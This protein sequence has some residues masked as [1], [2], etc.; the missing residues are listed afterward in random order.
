M[1]SRAGAGRAGPG[2]EGRRRGSGLG[3]RSMPSILV[4]HPLPIAASASPTPLTGPAG[5]SARASASTSAARSQVAI[6][7]PSQ[8]ARSGRA[9]MRIGLVAKRPSI[10]EAEDVEKPPEL[11]VVADGDHEV[12]VASLERL[13]RRDVRVRVAVATRLLAGREVVTEH[14]DEPGHAGLDEVHL[15][16]AGSAATEQRGQRAD[17]ALEA[18]EQIQQRHAGLGRRPVRVAGDRHQA[19]HRLRQQ[20]VGR[21]VGIG[22]G[23]AADHGHDQLGVARAERLRS[24]GPVGSRWRAG[25]CARADRPWRAGGRG[26]RGRHRSEGRARRS[27]CCG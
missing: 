2:A 14:V 11:R 18:G 9:P 4:V 13:V 27:A 8:A 24:P 20:V 19:A 5:T 6:R 25:S 26:S 10:L 3:A 15:H 16:R 23:K 21:A 17:R 22:A 1:C 7:S 12:A